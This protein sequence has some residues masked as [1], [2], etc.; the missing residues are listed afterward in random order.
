MSYYTKDDLI[1]LGAVSDNVFGDF[2]NI[3]GADKDAVDERQ[4]AD[5]METVIDD[6]SDPI[7]CLE[8]FLVQYLFNPSIKE[9]IEKLLFEEDMSSMPLYINVEQDTQYNDL[10][11]TIIARWRMKIGK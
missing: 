4:Y 7:A 5:L 2:G 11:K 6:T 3:I 1:C 10:P 8:E 9:D